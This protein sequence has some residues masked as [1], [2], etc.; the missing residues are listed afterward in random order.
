MKA[1][2]LDTSRIE[3]KYF[4]IFT[5]D[6][7]IYSQNWRKQTPAGSEWRTRKVEKLMVPSSGSLLDAQV[8]IQPALKISQVPQNLGLQ[9]RKPVHPLFIIISHQ[10]SK[11]VSDLEKEQADSFTF[12]EL[13][14]NAMEGN[15][16]WQIKGRASVWDL[17]IQVEIFVL[18]PHI[19]NLV[20]N[21]S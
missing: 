7:L 18:N 15:T 1:G 16:T 10:I 21:H 4:T 11:L 8:Y 12:E 9:F 13:C 6:N 3:N 20:A 14:N 19:K 5:C 17:D 2:F